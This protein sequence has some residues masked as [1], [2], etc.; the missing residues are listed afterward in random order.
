MQNDDSVLLKASNL[1]CAVLRTNEMRA[2]EAK[3]N[4][5]GMNGAGPGHGGPSQFNG[6]KAGPPPSGGPGGYPVQQ[7]PPVSVLNY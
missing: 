6:G 5:A 7:A 3:R 2:N 4:A 1:I